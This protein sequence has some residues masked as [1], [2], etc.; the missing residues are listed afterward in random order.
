MNCIICGSD[1]I[2]TRDTFFSDFVMA[3]ITDGFEPDK[4]MNRP[5]KLCFCRK[6]TFAFYDYRLTD[7]EADLLYKDYR[8]EEYQRTRERYECFYTSKVNNALNSD[9]LSLKH[10]KENITR[11]VSEYIKGGIETAL[12]YG[13]NEGRTFT[14][15]LGTREKY[16]YD[17]SGVKTVDG[18]RCISDRQE[19]FSH[20][21]DLIMCNQLFE[22]LA[23]PAEVLGF[24]RSLGDNDTYFYIE[25]PGENPF[26]MNNKFGI[27]KNIP[28]FFNP[29]YSKTRLVKYYF[30]RKKLPFMPMHE[31][32]N[33]FT[34]KSIRMLGELNGF[35]VITVGESKQR[36][37]LGD[38]NV[39]YT[40]FRLKR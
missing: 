21:Y 7:E 12:D 23:D 6:C 26:I 13:G 4:G 36:N 32:I 16:V 9:A 35:E 17:I 39:L 15:S 29:I 14:E 30:H 22:H 34:P 27:L 19:L 3:R 24:I 10:Q 37:V 5:V 25:V 2:E 20:R 40:L 11:V 38:S 33:F 1:D 28:M 31:H 8:G 18:V